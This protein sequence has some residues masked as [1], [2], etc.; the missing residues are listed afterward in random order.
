MKA[1]VKYTVSLC[2]IGQDAIYLAYL[3]ILNKKEAEK[4]ATSTMQEL[5][6]VGEVR[7]KVQGKKETILEVLEGRFGK[8]PK[9]ISDTV[10]SYS[11]ITAL[12][13]LSVLA[14]SCKTLGEFKDGLR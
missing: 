6:Q 8:V 11:D 4:M 3:K 5:I 7:G 13:S 10:K 2:R 14:G 9:S 12:Q 1:L